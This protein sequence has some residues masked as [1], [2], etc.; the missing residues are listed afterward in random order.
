[1][2]WAFDRK[3]TGNPVSIYIFMSGRLVLRAEANISHQITAG[4]MSVDHASTIAG[5]G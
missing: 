5:K 4:T 2:G 3:E 1:M